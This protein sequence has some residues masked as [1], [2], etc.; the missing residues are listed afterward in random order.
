MSLLEN[1]SK[2]DKERIINTIKTRK[3]FAKNNIYR[4]NKEAEW[5]IL[6]QYY[7][8]YKK[9]ESKY[10]SNIFVPICFEFIETVA[11]MIYKSLTAVRPY[12]T[13]IPTEESDI[14]SSMNQ[15]KVIDL[16]L[17]RREVNFKE[18]KLCEIKDSLIFGTAFTKIIPNSID[19]Y[20]YPIIDNTDVFNIFVHPRATSIHDA[21]YLIL[22]YIK[23]LQHIIENYEVTKKELDEIKENMIEIE[24]GRWSENKAEDKDPTLLEPTIFEYYGYLKIKE[25]HNK[26]IPCIATLVNEKNLIR[27]E[28]NPMGYNFKP[29]IR[30]VDTPMSNQFYGIGLLK[31]I[32]KLQEEINTRRNQRNDNL[33]KMINC[34]F[35][36]LKGGGVDV[37]QLTFQKPDMPLLMNNP[38][39][40]QLLTYP[41]V[42]YN[43]VPEMSMIRNDAVQTDGVFPYL[44]GQTPTRQETLGG[45]ITL[46]QAGGIRFSVKVDLT[47]DMG[48]SDMGEIIGKYN[49]KYLSKITIREILGPDSY[50]FDTI[51]NRDLIPKGKFDYIAVGSA[52]EGIANP[53]LRRLNY[54]K[55]FNIILALPPEVENLLPTGEVEIYKINHFNAIKRLLE[56]FDEKMINKILVKEKKVPQLTPEQLEGLKAAV[57]SASASL[58]AEEEPTLGEEKA[59]IA[60]PIT[61]IVPKRELRPEEVS[62]ES[63]GKSLSQRVIRS[64]LR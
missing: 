14:I 38:D 15:E 7:H 41:D 20:E 26:E 60:P 64:M 43:L 49:Q 29:I 11:P 2:D 12:I 36:I 53:Q 13:V 3:D 16:Q 32:Q 31:P 24:I 18:K 54:L 4:K 9:A 8:N 30:I 40:I 58:E 6:L 19:N 46:Q 52:E 59:G 62:A 42:T 21:Y 35:K 25:E 55:L 17:S 61:G 63:L 47:N 22:R 37:S 56:V 33:N 48:M 1:L 10:K 23:T 39:A 44:Q 5:N 57:Q 27:I 34:M 51:R 45:I 50:K 28:E